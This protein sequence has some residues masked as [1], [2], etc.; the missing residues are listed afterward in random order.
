MQD[1]AC[2]KLVQSI[3]DEIGDQGVQGM[4][5]RSVACL[6]FT[7]SGPL[8]CVWHI[9]SWKNNF[10][11]TLIQEELVISYW[12]KSGHLILVNCLWH[13][14]SWKK[15]TSSTGSRRASCQLLA[16]EWALN[17]GKLSPRCLRRNSVVIG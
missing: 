16:K 4:V 10:P 5:A 8:S 14:L 9:L 1:M 2:M 7:S 15:I 13:I 3:L 12:Q 17:T 11:L 6:C